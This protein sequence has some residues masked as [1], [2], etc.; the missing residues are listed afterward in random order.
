MTPRGTISHRADVA[1]IH[2]LA[3]TQRWQSRGEAC[4]LCRRR[5]SGAES[6]YGR[7][8]GD[9]CQRQKKLILHQGAHFWEFV[10]Q[11]YLH[12][13]ELTHARS[14]LVALSVVGQEWTQPGVWNR[15]LDG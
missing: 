13:C 10:L 5:W 11:I 2:P 1:R 8:P 15:G 12:E 4:G 7:T 9:G 3:K 6:F 14:V